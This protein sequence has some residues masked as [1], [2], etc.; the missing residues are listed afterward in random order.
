MLPT[1][2]GPF[3]QGKVAHLKL[4]E[5]TTIEVHSAKHV[6]EKEKLAAVAVAGAVVADNQH[7]RV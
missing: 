7:P 1:A 3:T 6:K 5:E 2:R 4:F